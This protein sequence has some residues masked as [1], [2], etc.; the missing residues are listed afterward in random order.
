MASNLY[1]KDI[2]SVMGSIIIHIMLA[3]SLTS[4]KDMIIK[5]RML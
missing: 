2:M 1:R 4:M 5:M 3:I